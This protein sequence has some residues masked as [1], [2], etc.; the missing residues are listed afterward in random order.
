VR[1]PQV[2]TEVRALVARCGGFRA[3]RDAEP[4]DVWV[5][6]GPGPSLRCG[7]AMV[8]P[9]PERTVAGPSIAPRVARAFGFAEVELGVDLGPLVPAE[10]VR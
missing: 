2:S 5:S 9:V 8:R 10:P 7:Y 1:K 6:L 3:A 4:P